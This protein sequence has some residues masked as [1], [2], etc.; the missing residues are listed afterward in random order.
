MRGVWSASDFAF[1]DPPVVSLI[2]NAAPSALED[3]KQNAA[4]S[5]GWRINLQQTAAA[6]AALAALP[7]VVHRVGFYFLQ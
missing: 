2:L 4:L 5:R 6:A 3:G 1:L 7:S